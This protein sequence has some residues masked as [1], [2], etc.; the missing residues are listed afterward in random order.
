MSNRY[1]RS[2]NLRILL[3]IMLLLL[4]VASSAQFA[5]APDAQQ[6]QSILATRLTA[7][8]TVTPIAVESG[9][10]LATFLT[11]DGRGGGQALLQNQNAAWVILTTTG[12]SL[13]DI[14]WL[15][16]RYHVPQSVAQAL[17]TDILNQGN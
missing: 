10:A 13:E 8:V 15:V 9:Y 11:T 17:I 14:N 16:N 5:P 12:G 1:N 2:T 3:S 6:I 4:P 7:T